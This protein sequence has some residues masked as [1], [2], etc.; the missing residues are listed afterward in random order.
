M[1]SFATAREFPDFAGVHT[2]RALTP[3]SAS[4]QAFCL[5][6]MR[7][8]YMERLRIFDALRVRRYICFPFALDSL[9]FFTTLAHAPRE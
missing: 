7:D 9:S 3:T 8:S 6:R 5:F 2:P 4:F 1:T